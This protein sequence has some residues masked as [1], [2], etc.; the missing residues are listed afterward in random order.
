VT[1]SS[2]AE[3]R[4]IDCILKTDFCFFF[5]F[6]KG[7]KITAWQSSDAKALDGQENEKL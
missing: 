6:E 4:Q 7:G 3:L 1:S 5:L 2:L